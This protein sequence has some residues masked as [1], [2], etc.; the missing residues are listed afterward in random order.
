MVVLGAAACKGDGPTGPSVPA[1]PEGS[2]SLSTVDAK[3]LPYMMYSDTGY[4]LEVMSGT[5]TISAGGKWVAKAVTRETVDGFVSTYSDSTFGT[6]TQ[7]QGA[8]RA[9]LTNAET[10]VQSSVTWTA[11]DLT[12]DDVDGTVTRKVVY[13]RN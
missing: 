11:S 2:Y 3:A 6:W 10:N 7:V 9:T 12:V 13:R 1:T 4:T 5:L 8:A